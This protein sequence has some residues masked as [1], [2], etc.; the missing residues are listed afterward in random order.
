MNLYNN[1]NYH[2]NHSTDHMQVDCL[3]RHKHSA[4]YLHSVCVFFL[5]SPWFLQE[6]AIF[7]LHSIFWLVFL[8]E[9]ECVYCETEADF[10]WHYPLLPC[11]SLPVIALSTNWL[12]PPVRKRCQQMQSS[13]SGFKPQRSIQPTFFPPPPNQDRTS[14]LVSKIPFRVTGFPYH[15]PSDAVSIHVWLKGPR[16]FEI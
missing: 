11:V 16:D 12:P 13:C 5:P 1:I 2:S 3:L 10:I 15:K 14:V 6:T 9:T 8:M 4:F 7:A